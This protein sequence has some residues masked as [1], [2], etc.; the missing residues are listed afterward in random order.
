MPVP[1]EENLNVY[2]GDEP[3]GSMS[4]CDDLPLGQVS[5]MEVVDDNLDPATDM[6]LQESPSDNDSGGNLPKESCDEDGDTA[7]EHGD[8]SESDEADACT[9]IETKAT[10]KVV[11]EIPQACWYRQKFE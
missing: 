7:M 9:E 5:L 11:L 6:H 8:N 4:T 10:A 3:D 1:L 2:Y